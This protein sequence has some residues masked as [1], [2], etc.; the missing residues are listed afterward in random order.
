VERNHENVPLGSP[1]TQWLMASAVELQMHLSMCTWDMCPSVALSQRISMIR[2]VRHTAPTKCNILLM[3][4]SAHGFPLGT[5]LELHCCLTLP[6]QPSLPPPPRW[7]P[8]GSLAALHLPLVPFPFFLH[9]NC[10]QQIEPM[11]AS[12]SWRT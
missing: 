9:T 2:I 7:Q 12:T 8:C 11:L 5:F 3:W 4:T 6:A 10:S 1:A